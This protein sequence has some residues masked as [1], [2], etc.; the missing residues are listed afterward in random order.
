MGEVSGQECGLCCVC[1]LTS[2]HR[3][4]CVHVTSE[5][6]PV[7]LRH[8]YSPGHPTFSGQPH[9]TAANRRI[10]SLICRMW[11]TTT[12][13]SKNLLMSVGLFIPTTHYFQNCFLQ[14]KHHSLYCN[15]GEGE[16]NIS[17]S[18]IYPPIINIDWFDFCLVHTAPPS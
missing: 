12:V 16:L 10:K 15:I 8:C 13:T 18:E 3:A 14:L 11:A 4:S 9:M 5:P 7:P 1:P 2:P 17:K 6:P